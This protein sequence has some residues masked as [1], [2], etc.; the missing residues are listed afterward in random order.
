MRKHTHDANIRTML[1]CEQAGSSTVPVIHSFSIV[2]TCSDW[3]QLDH[4]RETRIQAKLLSNFLCIGGQT[5]CHRA[6]IGEIVFAQRR[7]HIDA[8]V[9]FIA[10]KIELEASFN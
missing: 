6:H 8:P 4:T 9:I 7:C 10:T 3:L 2:W 5:C 1:T